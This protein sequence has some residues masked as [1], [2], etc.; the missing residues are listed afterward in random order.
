MWPPGQALHKYTFYWAIGYNSNVLYSIILQ[1]GYIA[2]QV[3]GNAC[4]RTRTKFI[5]L[6]CPVRCPC[7]FYLC[8]QKKNKPK[9][10]IQSQMRTCA[11]AYPPHSDHT[12]VVLDALLGGATQGFVGVLMWQ[13]WWNTPLFS[14]GGLDYPLPPP[15]SFL[16]KNPGVGFHHWNSV[17]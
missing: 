13:C 7:M 6:Q 11:L 17:I 4:L 10:H 9:L 2:K 1:L 12:W 14:F 5:P 3:V 8:W 16:L 15:P